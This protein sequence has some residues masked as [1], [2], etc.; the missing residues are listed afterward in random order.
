[1]R[2]L[3]SAAGE[4][5]NAMAKDRLRRARTRDPPSGGPLA[6]VLR[7]RVAFQRSTIERL[8]DEGQALNEELSV[9]KVKNKEIDLEMLELTRSNRECIVKNTGAR[10]ALQG[11]QSIL[12][13]R[14]KKEQLRFDANA[15]LVRGEAAFEA[16]TSMY[17]ARFA[18]EKATY[19]NGTK[20]LQAELQELQHRLSEERAHAEAMLAKQASEHAAALQ[21]VE[22]SI[23]SQLGRLEEM[24]QQ[25]VTA[26]RREIAQTRQQLQDASGD[27]QR[28]L[29]NHLKEA[30]LVCQQRIQ[31]EQAQGQGA[32][33][34]ELQAVSDGK[35]ECEEW[36]KRAVK[37]K[38]NYRA[39]SVKSRTYV[40]SL[41][42]QRKTQLQALWTGL[43]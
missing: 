6:E 11:E 4:V 26:L 7:H 29:E 17:T 34:A 43:S 1:V 28:H 9:T 25:R 39:H 41:D 5:Q 3:R 22:S 30:K 36:A 38:E 27:A 24:R 10:L 33:Q 8:R 32:I 15:T 42:P 12:I 37:V 18:E 20:G 16:T 2:E 19:L 14:R 21:D 35:R 13:Y 31:R 40:Q 23:S